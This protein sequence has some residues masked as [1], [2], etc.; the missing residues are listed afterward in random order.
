MQDKNIINNYIENEPLSEENLYK[1]LDIINE[2][3][4]SFPDKTI[5]LYTG[6]D[7]QDLLFTDCEY[8]E[9]YFDF[10]RKMIISKCDVVVD[11]K[12][13]DSQRDV[14]L[15]WRGSSNQKVID[16]KKSLKENKIVLYDE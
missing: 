3:R 15:H 14:T 16:I 5:W 2:F 10:L 6:Y 4:L 12:Y 7:L 11:G 13:I 1:V 9:S 8:E